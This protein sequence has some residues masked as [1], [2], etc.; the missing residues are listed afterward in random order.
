MKS[1]PEAVLRST[2]EGVLLPVH[3]TPGARRN[4]ISGMTEESDGTWR[5]K[6]SVTAVREGG[7]ANA[8]LIKFL[9]KSWGLPQSAISI[10][11]GA[12][13]RAKTLLVVSRPGP[14]LARIDLEM[15]KT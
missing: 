6:V 15:Q 8:A 9:A 5:L 13:A 11:S 10:K 2:G 14:L 12:K 1:K 7:K 4:A 3:L